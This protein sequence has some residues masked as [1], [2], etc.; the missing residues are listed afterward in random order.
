MLG[1]LDSYCKTRKLEHS[2]TIH[3]NKLQMDQRPK[4]KVIYILFTYIYTIKLR[5]NINRTLSDINCSCIIFDPP[6]NENKNKNFKKRMR[7]GGSGWGI[8]VC[9]WLIHVNVWQKPLQYCKVISLQIIKKIKIKKIK[10]K[11]TNKQKR[12]RLEN[13]MEVT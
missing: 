3:K 13:S 11:K 9:P 5:K 6:P 8:H 7:K 2:L 12:M 4:F 1:E 10:N